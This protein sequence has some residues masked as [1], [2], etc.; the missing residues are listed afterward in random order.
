VTFPNETTF[1]HES[2]IALLNAD[3]PRLNLI[4]TTCGLETYIQLLRSQYHSTFIKAAVW[5]CKTHL[6]AVIEVVFAKCSG[7]LKHLS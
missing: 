5:I 1:V 4:R 3:L 6:K 7:V 2:I